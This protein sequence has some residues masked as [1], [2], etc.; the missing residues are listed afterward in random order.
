VARNGIHCYESTIIIFSE[1]D[2]IR[3]EAPVKAVY[4]YFTILNIRTNGLGGKI[5][6]KQFFEQHR[7]R[8]LETLRE[9]IWSG[10]KS[11]DHCFTGGRR[12]RNPT[13]QRSKISGASDHLSFQRYL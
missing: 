8:L 13:C 3:R 10:G 2:H 1:P 5:E 4:F 12:Y 11:L 7:I 6:K 9:N